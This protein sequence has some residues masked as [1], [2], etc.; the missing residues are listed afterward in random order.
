MR[1]KLIDILINYITV[2]RIDFRD[3][4]Y[5]IDKSRIY[6]YSK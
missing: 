1:I 4:Y 5:G 6:R 3:L 2:I